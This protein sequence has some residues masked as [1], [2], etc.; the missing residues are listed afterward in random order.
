MQVVSVGAVVLVGLQGAA[1]RILPD[2]LVRTTADGRFQFARVPRIQLDLTVLA[3]G[4][5]G[6]GVD[7]GLAG[8][9]REAKVRHFDFMFDPAATIGGPVLGP[10]GRPVKDVHVLHY[11]SEGAIH[12]PAFKQVLRE[13]TE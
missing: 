12:G 4:K 10:D 5:I 11:N 9:C 13:P 2:M 8:M 7:R 1:A 6:R 3:P